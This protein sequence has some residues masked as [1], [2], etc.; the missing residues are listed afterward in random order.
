MSAIF[1]LANQKG[2]VAKTTTTGILAAGLKKQGF[3]VLTID[4]DPQGNSTSGMGVDKTVTPNCYDLLMN[5]AAA[6]D[7]IRSTKYGDVLPANMNLSGCSVELVGSAQREYIMK[8]ALAP[9]QA[10][11]DFILIDLSLIH[12]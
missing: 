10:D 4:C 6:A 5:G 3:S 1:A 12:I 9:V 7:C 2:G 11:Y 8:N